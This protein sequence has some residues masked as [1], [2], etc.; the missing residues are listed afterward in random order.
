MADITILRCHMIEERRDAFI[1]HRL[2]QRDGDATEPAHQLPIVF[3]PRPADDAI[4]EHL[5]RLPL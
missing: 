1:A 3:R 2:S 4:I 5:D